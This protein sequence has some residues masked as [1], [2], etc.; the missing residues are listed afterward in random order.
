MPTGTSPKVGQPS[1][2]AAP[3]KDRP[4]VVS[5]MV[6]LAGVAVNPQHVVAVGPNEVHTVIPGADG[7]VTFT[8]E[9]R[10]DQVVSALEFART[11]QFRN[12][13]GHSVFAQLKDLKAEIQNLKKWKADR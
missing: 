10:Q 13:A 11:Q 3:D 4:R 6:M 5:G 12:A 1:A 8:P 7:V 9:F 2:E